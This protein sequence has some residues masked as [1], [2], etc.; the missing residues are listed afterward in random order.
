MLAAGTVVS[1]NVITQVVRRSELIVVSSSPR[2]EYRAGN[3]GIVDE[4][5]IP[6]AID[7]R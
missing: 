7:H 4:A 6:V 2:T 1:N 3:E 5:E